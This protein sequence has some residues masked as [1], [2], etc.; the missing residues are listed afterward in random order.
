MSREPL[1]S[2]EIEPAHPMLWAVKCYIDLIS[3]PNRRLPSGAG[4]KTLFAMTT[5]TGSFNP[6]TVMA[7]TAQAVD[8]KLFP[9]DLPGFLNYSVTLNCAIYSRILAEMIQDRIMGIAKGDIR[10]PDPTVKF[11]AAEARRYYYLP[12]FLYV[13]RLT[14]AL[15]DPGNSV[16][17]DGY[18]TPV[19]SLE[20]VANESDYLMAQLQATAGHITP[21]SSSF[22]ALDTAVKKLLDSIT[23][24]ATAP[25]F[26]NDYLKRARPTLKV[27][28]FI[29]K[30]L[31]GDLSVAPELKDI[32]VADLDMVV[33]MTDG[34]LASIPFPTPQIVPLFDEPDSGLG[35][36]SKGRAYYNAVSAAAFYNRS[37]NTNEPRSGESC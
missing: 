32:N 2:Q 33:N 15:N 16:Y 18:H 11:N 25:G 20:M 9:G 26:C 22:G 13:Q 35:L 10:N 37:Y 30:L 19:V 34:T 31:Y 36:T 1:V 21:Q 14:K 8:M 5:G 29:A 23:T 27:L 12:T 6:D 3:Q 28:W 7:T 17:D 24:E 4:L